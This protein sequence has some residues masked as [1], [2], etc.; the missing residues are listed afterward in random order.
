M[1]KTG[2][3][4]TEEST[5]ARAIPPQGVAFK[6]TSV[7]K[8]KSPASDYGKPPQ[9]KAGLK[10]FEVVMELTAPKAAKGIEVKTWFVVGIDDDPMLKDPDNWSVA[11]DSKHLKRLFVRTGTPIPEDD[12]EFADALVG[13]EGCAHT[14][15][16]QKGFTGIQ[17]GQYYRESDED[18]VGIGTLL[19]A[20]PTKPGKQQAKAAGKRPVESEEEEEEAPKKVAKPAKLADDDDDD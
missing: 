1:A 17:K 9:T 19:E 3:G 5:G 14:F 2:L 7:E 10:Q 15:V 11:K 13:M 4:A 20:S 16:T 18:F 6:I 8:G 12:D